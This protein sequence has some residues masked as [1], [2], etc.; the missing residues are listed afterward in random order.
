MQTIISQINIVVALG[1]LLS[2]AGLLVFVFFVS[3]G[4]QIFTKDCSWLWLLFGMS[5]F[6]TAMSLVYSEIFGFVPCGLCW[7]QRVFLYPQVII[8]G[9]AIYTKDRGVFDY[10]IT[11]SFAG[12]IVALYQFFLQMGISAPTICPVSGAENCANPVLLEFGFVTFPFVSLSFFFSG[13][14]QYLLPQ[15]KVRHNLRF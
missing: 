6:G 15:R 4:K 11:L 12:T 9:I 10:I 5:F 7:L 14:S 2:L 13:R 8:A 3:R 1:A